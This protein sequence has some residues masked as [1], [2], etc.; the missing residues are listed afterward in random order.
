ML[1]SEP[2]D[3]AEPTPRRSVSLGSFM[4]VITLVAALVFIALSGRG[5]NGNAELIAAADSGDTYAIEEAVHDGGSLNYMDSEGRTAV[6]EA[7]LHG[8]D[9]TVRYLLLEH[10]SATPGLL[11]A[12]L[13]KDPNC[14]RVLIEDGA[15]CRSSTGSDALSAALRL[16]DARFTRMLRSGGALIAKR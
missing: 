1:S 11:N 8:D 5:H 4:T 6:G 15:D 7:A 14:L 16:G 2:L 9:V 12:V 3:L 13:A 10:A